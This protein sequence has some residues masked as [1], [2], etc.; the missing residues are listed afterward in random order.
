VSTLVKPLAITGLGVASLIIAV[1]IWVEISSDD[2]AVI[3]EVSSDF[4][5]IGAAL[6]TYKIN[7]GHYP[8][9]EQGLQALVERPTI[10]PLPED[11]VQVMTKVPKDPWGSEYRYRSF[12]EGSPHPF[13][14]IRSGPDGIQGTKDDQSSL[15]RPHSISKP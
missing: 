4:S 6:R 5:S 12:P 15:H 1:V 3:S 9:T 2:S 13:E 11:W 14:L 10:P 7:A 8:T